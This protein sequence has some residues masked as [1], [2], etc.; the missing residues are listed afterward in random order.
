VLA[1]SLALP[2]IAK[3]R[4]KEVLYDALGTGDVAWSQRLGR[5]AMALLYAELE[6]ELRAGRSAVVEA[7]FAVA[8]SRP[9]LIALRDRWPF[10]PFEI[11]CTAGAD[12]LVARYSAR[13]GS[14]HAGHLDEQRVDE[15]TRAIV[16]GRNGPL[17]L[18]P[19]VFVLDTT[20]PELV[21]TG[22]VV[23]AARRHLARHGHGG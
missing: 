2:L 20:A 13:A 5:T 18:G 9:A 6:G 17:E 15:I 11:H 4:T 7:N 3:D 8:E 22:S 16:E 1:E 23:D 21:D 19:D 12:V 14:R 10:A